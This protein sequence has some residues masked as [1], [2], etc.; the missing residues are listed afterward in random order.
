MSSEN[1]LS[2]SATD[3]RKDS[4][5]ERQNNTTTP[6]KQGVVTIQDLRKRRFSPD[7]SNEAEASQI[8]NEL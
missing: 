8:T 3:A 2:P 4:D 1:V 7:S 5:Q 6:S